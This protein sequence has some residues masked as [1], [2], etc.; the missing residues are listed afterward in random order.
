MDDI[1]FNNA[2][3]LKK[4]ELRYEGAPASFS[5]IKI[6]L[7]QFFNCHLRC[8]VRNKHFFIICYICNKLIFASENYMNLRVSSPSVAITE[9]SL[10]A[11]LSFWF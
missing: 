6:I 4:L 7:S 10:F 9:F 11:I 1:Y 5:A 2:N 8:N 3:N